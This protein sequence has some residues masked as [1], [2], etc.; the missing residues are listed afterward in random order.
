MSTPQAT[1]PPA[2]P[3]RRRHR[4]I[5]LLIAVVAAVFAVLPGLG[6]AALFAVRHHQ[7]RTAVWHR[8]LTLLR[9]SAPGANVTVIG[10]QPGLTQVE[11]HLTWF[12]GA[13]P[14][15]RETWA[16][17]TLT[18]TAPPCG[19]KPLWHCQVYLGIQVPA[20]VAV[21]AGAGAGSLNVAGLT[22]PVR[23]WVTSGSIS[24]LG[25]HGPAWATA[26]SGA[27]SA[28]SLACPRLHAAVS[29]GSLALQF[30]LPPQRVTATATSGD[31]SVTVPPGTR[32]RVAGTRGSG[33]VGLAPGLA[34]TGSPR[35]ITVSSISGTVSVGYEYGQPVAP[36][37]PPKVKPAS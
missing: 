15:I 22:G 37:P 6:A 9:V 16:G 26:T 31:V 10:G 2:A 27:I 30:V 24:L 23:T 29:S 1:A 8:P 17:R 14:P 32:Y 5:W 18:I 21:Q 25:L 36:L 35:L 7:D 34:S 28:A 3:E 4:G 13:A 11:H 33:G 12:L 20:G 19:P